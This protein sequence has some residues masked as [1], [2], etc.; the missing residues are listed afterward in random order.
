MNAIV[1]ACT[2]DVTCGAGAVLITGILCAAF[3]HSTAVAPGAR[4]QD[5]PLFALHAP[6]P[7]HAWFGQPHPAVL[8]D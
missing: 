2:R 6:G 7:A 1:A 8:V 3:L 5:K 4:T